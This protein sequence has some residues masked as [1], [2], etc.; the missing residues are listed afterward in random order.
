MQKIFTDFLLCSCRWFQKLLDFLRWLFWVNICM[1]P[2]NQFFPPPPQSPPKT[3]WKFKFKFGW[4]WKIFFK[5]LKAECIFFQVW[6]LKHS[7]KRYDNISLF[8][9][10]SKSDSCAHFLHQRPQKNWCRIIIGGVDSSWRSLVICQK[11]HLSARS[12]RLI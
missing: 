8:L 4:I 7:L 9:K 6:R 11:A 2:H 5:Q 10:V 1:S 12:A 3:P